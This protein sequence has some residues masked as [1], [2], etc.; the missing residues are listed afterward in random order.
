MTKLIKNLQSLISE[1]YDRKAEYLERSL[2]FHFLRKVDIGEH[3]S[4]LTGQVDI[5]KKD[6]NLFNKAVWIPTPHAC[7]SHTLH[8]NEQSPVE[9]PT[10][11]KQ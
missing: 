5:Q 6:T 2:R 11:Q 10:E 1:G 4:E 3:A 7:E 9:R 8:P